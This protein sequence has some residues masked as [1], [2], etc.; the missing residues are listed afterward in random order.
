M[1]D[2]GNKYADD[3]PVS[4]LNIAVRVFVDGQRITEQHLTLPTW[5]LERLIGEIA[6][7]HIGLIKKKGS[8]IFMVEFEFVDAPTS[9]RFL[10]FGTD[11]RCMVQPM[12]VSFDCPHCDGIDGMCIWCGRGKSTGPTQ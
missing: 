9:E 11:P 8:D 2:N 12:A 10:R 7:R 6:D 1:R 4:F 3:D 5:E